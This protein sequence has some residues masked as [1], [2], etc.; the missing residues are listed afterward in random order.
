MIEELEQ[1]LTQRCRQLLREYAKTE[2]LN[3]DFPTNDKAKLMH[4]LW[5]KVEAYREC[6]AELKSSR[7][8]EL[9]FPRDGG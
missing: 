9:P 4:I 7:E 2:G 6:I 8:Q 3:A 5:G 1:K